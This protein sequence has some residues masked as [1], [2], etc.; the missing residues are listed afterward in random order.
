MS[1][2][3]VLQ[4]AARRDLEEYYYWAAKHA[5][6]TAAKWYK[7]FQESL[8]GLTK[9]PKRYALAPENGKVDFEI[10]QFLFGR[11]PN[12][13]RVIFTVDLGIVRVLLI[14]R[15]QRRFLTRKQIEE[16]ATP[17]DID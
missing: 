14:R 13:Y 4:S 7:R 2:R 12:V 6:E 5:P 16:S 8:R 3:L 10:R 9:N 17:D 15:G 1:Y 11:K